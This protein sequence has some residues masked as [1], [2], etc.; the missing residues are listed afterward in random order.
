MELHDM[1][2]DSHSVETN[3]FT[4]KA[5]EASIKIGLIFLL[6][7]WCFNIAKPF[8]NALA[9][10][11][12][13]AVA[14]YPLHQTLSET[15]GARE[16]LSAGLIT[17]LLLLIILV[18]CVF[19][20]NVIGDNVRE[21]AEKL[22]QETFTIPPPNEKVAAWPLIGQPIFDFW[23]QAA[24]NIA[25]TLKTFVPQLKALSKWLLASGVSAF[26]AILQLLV[27]VVICGMLLVNGTS[28]HNLALTIG[29]RV[30]GSKGDELTALC[31]ATIRG[32]ARG[33]LGVALI[34]SSLAGVGFFSAHV[35]GAALLTI[36]CL[37]IAIVQLPTI[38]LILPSIVYVFSTHETSTSIVFMIWMLAVGLL[39]N[40]LKP[41]LLGR[42]VDL[43][44]AVV[45]IGAIG[46]MIFSGIIGLFVGAVV[47]ALGYKLFLSWLTE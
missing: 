1:Q 24:S 29:R 33:V 22:R 42:G 41:F 7:S 11:T 34:Q 23:Q 17:V 27:A 25:E 43:P 13:I 46:G 36:L 40:V 10:G 28:G 20:G 35:P 37:F 31:I 32:V 15:L 14:L 9:W 44:M 39:D 21:V 38:I 30:A 19:L 2:N 3:D 6:L 16:K 8:I 18:P 4:R 26:M 5:L 12:I 47:L 45:F